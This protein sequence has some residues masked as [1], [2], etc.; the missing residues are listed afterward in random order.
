[1][2]FQFLHQLVLIYDE[3][4]VGSWVVTSFHTAVRGKVTVVDSID[5]VSFLR[6]EIMI[7]NYQ[8]RRAIEIA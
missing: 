3:W 7:W 2:F 4:T 8:S 1:M 6:D 5:T